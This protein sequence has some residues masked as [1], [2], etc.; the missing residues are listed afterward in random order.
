MLPRAMKAASAAIKGAWPVPATA[1]RNPQ[2]HQ[3]EP[4]E[5]KAEEIAERSIR[6]RSCQQS[7]L[8]KVGSK[9]IAQLSLLMS[10][11]CSTPSLRMAS[12]ALP[13][14]A[15]Y[16]KP[17]HALRKRDSVDALLG[18]SSK[19]VPV[20]GDVVGQNARRSRTGRCPW[21]DNSPCC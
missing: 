10:M 14:H 17:W 20:F 21:D 8:N 2:V 11:N 4:S 7:C 18:V 16:D 13:C 5:A 19:K 15:S 9:A 1:G 3:P 6:H 12:N